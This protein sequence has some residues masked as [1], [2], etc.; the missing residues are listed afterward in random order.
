MATVTAPFH[1][2]KI[3]IG[4]GASPEVF[5]QLCLLNTSRSFDM[6]NNMQDDEVPDCSDVEA[7][8]TILRQIR[9]TDF[10]ISGEGKL[11]VINLATVLA[12]ANG[13]A[14]RNV[15]IEVGTSSNGGQR[16]S[17]AFFLTQFSV[18]GTFKEV[19]TASVTLMP[20]DSGAITIA[21]LA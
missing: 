18:S 11:H 4:D 6:T 5:T 14:A 15:R 9:S 2:V 17:G 10:Q 21:A 16:I 13:G 8:A 20:A 1:Q 3:L 19:A 7:P 12:W